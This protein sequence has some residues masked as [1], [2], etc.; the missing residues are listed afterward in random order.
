MGP[1][2]I[3]IIGEGPGRESKN[4]I[5]LKTYERKT[6]QKY[7][8]VCAVALLTALP[9]IVKSEPSVIPIHTDTIRDPSS[10]RVLLYIIRPDTARAHPCV[11]FCPRFGSDDPAEYCGLIEHVARQGAVVVFPTYEANTFTRRSVELGPRTDEI[12]SLVSRVI[13]NLVDTTRIGFI[14]HSYG[15][16]I[17]P[18]IA[19]RVLDRTGWGS[20][21]S[22]LYLMSPWYFPGTSTR[23]LA[24]FPP[25]AQVI[26]QV[27]SD[28]N[29]NDPRIGAYFFQMLK[30]PLNRKEF[31][32]VP[33][34]AGPSRIKSDFLVPLSAEAFDGS[35]DILDSSA[36]FCMVD[37][38]LAGVFGEDSSAR[39]FAFGTGK[40]RKIAL[41]NVGDTAF[42]MIATD[43]PKP[44]L[45]VRPYINSWISPRNPFVEVTQFR[46][47]R[48][49]YAEFKRQKVSNTLSY[50]VDKKRGESAPND[51]SFDVLTNPIDTGFG[52]DGTFSIRIDTVLDKR[53]GFSPAYF[54]RP[55]GD[56]AR[57]WP[58]VI[59]LHGYTGQDYTF[60]E[61]YISHMVSRGMAVLYPTY[62]KLPVASSASRVAEK[63]AIA[64]TGIDILHERFGAV[65]DTTRVGV[66][67]QSF[68][69]GMVPAIGLYFF[70][71]RNWGA[72]G[73]YLYLTAP[74]YCNGISE[75]ELTSLPQ[76]VKMVTMIFDEDN[77]NDHAIAIDIHHAVA[78]PAEQKNFITLFSDSIDGM[79]MRADHFV[80]YGTG[81]VYGQENYLDYYGVYR[82]GDALAA[83]S[84]YGSAEGKSIAMGDGDGRQRFMGKRLDNTLVKPAGITRTPVVLHPQDDY[85][86]PWENPLNPRKELRRES[87][88]STMIR[89]RK[90]KQK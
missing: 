45:S 60:F 54:F 77:I 80:P 32:V 14:G 13:K 33:S 43:L 56:T 2:S 53:T 75:S 1:K 61:P 3:G 21:G 12:F 46:K 76:H 66:Q 35:D 71:R 9:G 6:M 24:N 62:P 82:F 58:V 89:L 69:G 26:V 34:P 30:L 85:F 41:G 67:G 50:A 39:A 18:A 28:D 88:D 36:V 74:W 25:S 31:L 40:T 20:N 37:S 68:G 72:N 7:F 4:E 57:R 22:F 8:Y 47:A 51:S 86:Y 78:L 73:A 11:L 19:T 49:M 59:L 52:A 16:G 48:R 90:P 65:L 44:Y 55:D 83:Y 87:S 23:S 5:A 38:V 79:V 17:I 29:I 70:T 42:A 84:F 10:Q 27:F 81:Y 63:L 64:K 15:A